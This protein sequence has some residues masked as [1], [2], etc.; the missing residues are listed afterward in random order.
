MRL[1]HLL[2]RENERRNDLFSSRAVWLSALFGLEGAPEGTLFP[3]T[4]KTAQEKEMQMK[5][6]KEENFANFTG[7]LG[8]KQ[9]VMNIKE[10]TLGE[11]NESY[12]SQATKG[13]RRMPR[14]PGAKKGVASCEKPWGAAGRQ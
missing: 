4:L 2:S 13:I 11:E 12:E 3:C 6:S 5:E 10:M 9:E 1:D 7:I 8:F 14:R